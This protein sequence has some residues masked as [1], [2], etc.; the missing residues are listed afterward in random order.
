MIF[1]KYIKGPTHYLGDKQEFDV[2]S[3]GPSPR[4]SRSRNRTYARNVQFLFIAK[5][6]DT[7][8]HLLLII[9][10]PNWPPFDIIYIMYHTINTNKCNL[11][12]PKHN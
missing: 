10:Y 7:L 6:V 5:V 12:Y 4:I 11:N 8:T 1:S 9:R 3:V 2:S